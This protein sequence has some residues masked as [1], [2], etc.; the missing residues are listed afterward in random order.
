MMVW[1]GLVRAVMVWLESSEL[2]FVGQEEEEKKRKKRRS[3]V[4]EMRW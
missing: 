1:S 3:W 2:L 4:N